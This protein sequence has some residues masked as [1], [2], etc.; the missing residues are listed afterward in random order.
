MDIKITKAPTGGR[1]AAIP[2]KSAAHRIL[3][4]AVLTRLDIGPHCDGL[5]QDI[6]ATKTCLQALTATRPEAGQAA[7]QLPCGESGSTLRFL[8]P[9]AGVLGIDADLLC[10]G[11]LPDRPMQPFLE[12]LAQHGCQVTGRNP[13]KLRGQLTGGDFLLPGNISSQYVTGLLMALPLAE[14][15]SRIIVE[16]TLQSRPYIDLTLE[17]LRRAEIEVQENEAAEG[18]GDRQAPSVNTVFHVPGR[19]HY[20][21]PE[22]A[23]DHIEGDWSN[24]AFWLAMDAMIP[25]SIDCTGLDAG[26]SQGDKAITQIIRRIE[27]AGSAPVDIDVAD[28]PDLVPITTALACSRPAGAVTNIVNAGRLRMKES[29]RLTSV[30]TVLSTLGADITELPEGLTI[31]GTQGLQGGEVSGWGDHRIAMMAAVA[32]CIAS[33]DIIIRGAEAVNKSYPA[34]F[35]DYR[36][37][38]GCAEVVEEQR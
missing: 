34:F 17:V 32:A 15:D 13:K 18:V 6:T 21:L 20:R 33:G 37:L 12:V 30:R 3:I 4:A 10:E 28:V 11:R 14:E 22:A 35:D 16:G 9:V 36:A 27:S 31:R 26:S 2:S 5:S 7:A 29:D 1:V 25:G 38:G 8:I 23:L 19:Q 24:A